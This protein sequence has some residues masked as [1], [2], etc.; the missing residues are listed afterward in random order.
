MAQRIDPVVPPPYTRSMTSTRWGGH[1]GAVAGG[2]AG[3]LRV[4]LAVITVLA[5]LFPVVDHHL[6]DRLSGRPHVSSS[7]AA[8]NSAHQ[9]EHHHTTRDGLVLT[10]DAAGP[11]VRAATALAAA[12][13]GE[14]LTGPG[15]A[16]VHLPAVQSPLPPDALARLLLYAGGPPP[17]AQTVAPDLPPPVILS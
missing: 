1:A 5:L 4:M 8:V 12:T 13:I 2:A 7:R 3:L 16:P 11:V 15:R 14:T 9:H 10:T 17:L 6:A